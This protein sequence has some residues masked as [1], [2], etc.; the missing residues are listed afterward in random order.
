M[1]QIPRIG[2]PDEPVL[3]RTECA[4]WGGQ[5]LEL[6]LT[7]PPAISAARDPEMG[8]ALLDAGE[9][10]IREASGASA[11]G[12]ARVVGSKLSGYVA[13]RQSRAGDWCRERHGTRVRAWIP[14][15]GR[16]GYRD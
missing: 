4:L 7:V 11:P 3:E 8:L 16:A 13:C 14:Q 2:A 9:S 12:A 1:I 10:G 5:Q 6:V 15:I